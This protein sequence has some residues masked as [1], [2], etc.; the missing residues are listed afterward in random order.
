ML[1]AKEETMARV[2]VIS[3]VTIAGLAGALLGK[4]ACRAR[5]GRADRDGSFTL[6]RVGRIQ[7]NDAGV[8]IVIEPGLDDALLGLDGFSHVWVLWWFDRNDNADKRSV[9]RVHPKGNPENPLTGVFATRSP[10]R[11]NLVAMTLCKI[12]RIEGNTVWIDDI[13]ALDR[14]PVVDLKPYIPRYDGDGDATTP[15]WVAR[16]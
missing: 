13:D 8:A 5:A 10:A 6:R 3:L 7:K 9:L 1:S 11:P 12:R 2:P 4:T 14:T 16:T 15:S